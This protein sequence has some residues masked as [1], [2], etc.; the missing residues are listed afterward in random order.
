MSRAFRTVLLLGVIAACGDDATRDEP[1]GG[2]AVAGED[3]GPNGGASEPANDAGRAAADVP[4]PQSPTLTIDEETET[5]FTVPTLGVRRFDVLGLP[6]GA[7]FDMASGAFTFRPDFTQSGTYSVVVTGHMANGEPTRKLTIDL[8]VRDSI[9]PPEPTIISDVA[10]WGFHRLVV[11]QLTDSFLDA[12]GRAGR[13]VD[14]VVV[15]PDSATTSAPAPVEVFLHGFDAGPNSNAASTATFRIEPHDPD[16]TYWW[17]YGDWIPGAP[18]PQ[19]DVKG[20]TTRRVL[21]LVDWLLRTHPEADRDRVFST[22]ISMGGAGALVLGFMYARH[23]AGIEATIGQAIARNHRPSRIAQLTGW[24]G[25][26]A[27]DIGDV[28]NRLDVTRMLRDSLEARDQFAFTKHG[29]DDPTIHFGAAVTASPLTNESFYAAL[30]SRHVGHYS[31]WDEGAHGP[32]DPLLG[33]GWWDGGWNR[34][35]DPTSYLTR[36]AP[37]PAFSRSTANESPIGANPSNGI[38]AFDPESGYAG[39]VEVP[40]DTG[41]SG[42]IAGAFNR[43]LRWDTPNVVDTADKLL[44]PL[45]AVTTSGDAPPAPGYPTRRDRYDGPL[46]IVVDVTPRRA[47]AFRPMP[48]E[49]V[50]YRFAKTS[51]VTT[52]DADGAVTVPSLP[53]TTDT[54]VLELERDPP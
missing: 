33:N 43:F 32:A 1:T 9:T 11:R 7:R 45:R 38:R 12:P 47:S 21:H 42:A 13:T 35:L 3:A 10:G 18:S 8:T 2:H 29:K 6:P 26:P 51:G 28:W 49:S 22:G 46:P 4:W 52:A 40:G 5:T 41:W 50:H 27:E 19:S 54:T 30:E 48:G 44:L 15:V 53:I 25:S 37:F 39:R 24:W 31:V 23:F 14:A 17:G 16:N 36:R 20:Y 34:M